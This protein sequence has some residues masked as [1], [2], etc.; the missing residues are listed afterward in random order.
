MSDPKTDPERQCEQN[1]FATGI[2]LRAKGQD[3]RWGSYDIAELDRASLVEFL[4]S[5]GGQN[6]WAENVVL[7]ML[8]HAPLQS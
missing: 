4:R 2:Y 8:A 5:R 3:G 1:H 6:V 7:I